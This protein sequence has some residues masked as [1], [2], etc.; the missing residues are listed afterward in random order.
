MHPKGPLI[1]ISTKPKGHLFFKTKQERGAVRNKVSKAKIIARKHEVNI[2]TAN[3]SSQPRNGDFH[4]EYTKD[5]S[6]SLSVSRRHPS[7]GTI[8]LS[9]KPPPLQLQS[10]IVR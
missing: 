5:L 1:D 4:Y 10:L 8:V 6:Q 2:A 7:G 3:Y 9:P